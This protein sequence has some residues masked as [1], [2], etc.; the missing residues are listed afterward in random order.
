[1]IS[2]QAYLSSTLNSAAFTRWK[3][4][5]QAFHIQL[6]VINTVV[7]AAQDAIEADDELAL[8]Q[9]FRY[10]RVLY[11]AATAN[12]VYA[13]DFAPSYYDKVI[14]PSMKPPYLKAGFT[15]LL[16][17]EHTAMQKS[18]RDLR[19]ALLTKFGTSTKIWPTPIAGAWDEVMRAKRENRMNHGLVCQKFVPD[20]ASLLKQFYESRKRPS[21]TRSE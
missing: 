14:R 15:G 10:L 3:L 12:M 11:E 13:S 8:V 17:T 4:G 18:M 1:M 5:H 9:Q 20:G 7:A 16:N 19:L 2:S 21:G 6:V